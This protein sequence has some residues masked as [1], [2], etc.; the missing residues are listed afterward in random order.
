MEFDLKDYNSFYSLCSGKHKE[1]AKEVYDKLPKKV[2]KKIQ[3]NH[4]MICDYFFHSKFPDKRI[5]GMPMGF[6]NTA[7]KLIDLIPEETRRLSEE[8]LRGLIAHEVAHFYIESLFL[9]IRKL[10]RFIFLHRFKKLSLDWQKFYR[11]PEELHADW[12]AVRWGFK[13][14]I[15]VMNKERQIKL[16]ELS[17]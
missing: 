15:E 14:D 16:S 2:R 17:K 8:G 3:G 6:F 5:H 7:S 13:K 11:E 4:V 9:P 1:I 10:K 12:V